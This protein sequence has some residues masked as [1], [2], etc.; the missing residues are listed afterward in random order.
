VPKTLSARAIGKQLGDWP[1]E[2][3]WDVRSPEV[4]AILAKVR[5]SQSNERALL[6]VWAS[7]PMLPAAVGCVNEQRIPGIK[8][9]TGHS[10]QA[11]ALHVITHHAVGVAV[12]VIPTPGVRRMAG[13][14][15]RHLQ[16]HAYTQVT[17]FCVTLPALCCALQRIQ[18]CAD[19][20]FAGID[21]GDDT[22]SS[23]SCD[24]Q[25]MSCPTARMRMLMCVE[26]ALACSVA[27][28]ER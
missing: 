1:D 15:H 5:H 19:K 26:V 9:F 25:Q 20:G 10:H 2:K 11:A 4:R 28:I 6:Y 8:H 17:P 24:A 13:R 27:S 21:P 18:Q 22:G 7:A 16:P 23:R 3:Y 12:L 14:G